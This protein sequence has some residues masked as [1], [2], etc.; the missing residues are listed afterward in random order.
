ME[1]EVRVDTVFVATCSCGEEESFVEGEDWAWN[2]CT[3]HLY[4]VG[5]EDE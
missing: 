2:W 5:E 1:H 4:D 3:D